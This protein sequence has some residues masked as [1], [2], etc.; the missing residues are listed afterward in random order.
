MRALARLLKEAL[1]L[2]LFNFDLIRKAG[3]C[4]RFLVVDINYFPGIAKMPDYETVFADFLFY[5]AERKRH[6]RA[7]AHAIGCFVLCAPLRL[8]FR[9]CARWEREPLLTF[10][11]SHVCADLSTERRTGVKGESQTTA[12]RRPLQLWRWPARMGTRTS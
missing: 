10:V 5:S 7:S 1:G 12:A 11:A 2:E 9:A 4:D 6:R 8:L 3:E